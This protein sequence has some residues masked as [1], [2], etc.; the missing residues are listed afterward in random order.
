M[1]ISSRPGAGHL[2]AICSYTYTAAGHPWINQEY[3]SE[4]I[5]A[6]LGAFAGPVGWLILKALLGLGVFA[7]LIAAA[8]RHG[9]IGCSKVRHKHNRGPRRSRLRSSGRNG[10]P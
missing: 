6:A 3:L 1:S 5:F 4:V 10:L 9:V 8:N 7:L 2:P